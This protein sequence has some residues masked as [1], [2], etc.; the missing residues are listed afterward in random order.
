MIRIRLEHARRWEI[1]RR[2]TDRLH[3]FAL[4]SEPPKI[5]NRTQQ[6]AQ[7]AKSRLLPRNGM[8][9]GVV[10]RVARLAFSPRDDLVRRRLASF[11][12]QF[13]RKQAPWA[14]GK[15]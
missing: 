6:F 4:L 5:Q 14:L 2:W 7:R 8:R 12:E 13:A 15:E 11:E 9:R 10:R 1:E 3:H